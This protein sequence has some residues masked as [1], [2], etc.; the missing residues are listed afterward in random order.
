MEEGDECEMSRFVA[1]VAEGK[2]KDKEVQDK[3][4]CAE[5]EVEASSIQYP[6]PRRHVGMG[7]YGAKASSR[8]ELASVPVGAG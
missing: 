7:V 3:R 8:Q 2:Y 6:A 4:G 5:S 1:W